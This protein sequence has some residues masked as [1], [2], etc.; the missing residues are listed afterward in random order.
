MVVFGTLVAPPTRMAVTLNH[1]ASLPIIHNRLVR[2]FPR[3]EEEA[4]HDVTA[5]RTR[6]GD[7]WHRG[8]GCCPAAAGGEG[9]GG[10]CGGV[11][12]ESAAAQ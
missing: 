12:D 10:V 9:V 5:C 4:F 3:R 8:V 6:E 1:T 2:P 7:Q 11:G